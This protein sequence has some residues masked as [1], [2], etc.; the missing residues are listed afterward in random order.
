MRANY[1]KLRDAIET[2]L[3]R[4]ANARTS[5]PVT[6][7]MNDDVRTLVKYASSEGLL[8]KVADGIWCFPAVDRTSQSTP[9][10][11]LVF[12]A[13]EMRGNS[14]ASSAIVS[15]IMSLKDHKLVRG[16]FSSDKKYDGRVPRTLSAE[17]QCDTPPPQKIRS[18]LLPKHIQLKFRRKSN[19]KMVFYPVFL[20]FLLEKNTL[21]CPGKKPSA[22]LNAQREKE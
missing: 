3:R 7:D 1:R 14:K 16:G 11:V 9:V 15:L 6:V 17:Q 20:K 18:D 13:I 10:W 12:V 4:M 22:K 8:R 2:I 21:G 19:K 5:L